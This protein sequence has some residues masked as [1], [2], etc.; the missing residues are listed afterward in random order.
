MRC[1]AS[2]RWLSCYHGPTLAAD[3]EIVLPTVTFPPPLRDLT[4][5]IDTVDVSQPCRDLGE[6]IDRLEERFPGLASRVLAAGKLAPGIAVAVDHEVTNRGL[7]TPIDA[8]S[9]VHFLPAIAGG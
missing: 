8:A 4:G 5:Q 1:R 7:Y 2:T 3:L 6:L 9:I